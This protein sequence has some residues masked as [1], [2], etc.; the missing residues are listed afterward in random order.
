MM[1]FGAPRLGNKEFTRVYRHTVPESYRVVNRLDIVHKIPFFLKHV[2]RELEFEED[3]AVVIDKRQE[4]QL[5]EIEDL[6]T[7]SVNGIS[8]LGDF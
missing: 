5:E 6:T 8:T 1:N 2:N 7:E 3:G 4:I